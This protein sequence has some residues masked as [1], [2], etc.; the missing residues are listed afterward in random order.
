MPRVLDPFA[1]GG[2]IPLEAM[3]LGCEA[4]AADINPVAWFILR[5]TLHYPRLLAGEARPLPSFALGDRSFVEAFLK[6]HGVTKANAVRE[7]LARYGHGDG[8]AV[9]VAAPLGS[10]SASPAAG[11]DFAWHL[12]AWGRRVLAGAR[13]VR[14]SDEWEGAARSRFRV[15]RSRVFR[16]TA[17]A[18]SGT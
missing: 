16:A 14:R 12:R 1:G 4:V 8:E 10:A 9:Q 17:A 6:A 7:E 15:P 5:C 18:E 11:A 13:R 2:A 3:R